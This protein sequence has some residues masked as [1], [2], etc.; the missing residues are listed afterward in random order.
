MSLAYTTLS[1]AITSTQ[2]SFGV[3]SATNISNA[4]F[5]GTSVI[6]SSTVTYLLVEQ[7]AM[8]VIT[9]AGT[10]VSVKRGMLGTR[11]MAHATLSPCLSGL[12]T[13]FLGFVPAIKAFTVVQ[14][15]VVGLSISASVASAASIIASGPLFRTTGT[16]AMTNM[17]PPSS[18]NLSV[19]GPN[20]EENYING[21]KVTIIF[22]GSAS[23]LTWTAAGGGT[24]PAFSVAGTSTTALSSVDFVLDGSTGTFLWY[25]SRLA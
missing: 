14:P 11:A 25:P 21:T 15:E 3:T 8:Q 1:G 16:V 19:A 9:I 6:G 2:S 7:E 24:G 17:L 22:A 10:V 18:V 20:S 4:V 23:G 5:Q 13:D 12:S